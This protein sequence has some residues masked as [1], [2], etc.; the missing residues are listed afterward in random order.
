MRTWKHTYLKKGKKGLKK[1]T[2]KDKNKAKLSYTC[3]PVT[4][5]LEE[6][7]QLMERQPSRSARRRRP[8]ALPAEDSTEKSLEDGSETVLTEGHR[9]MQTCV[10]CF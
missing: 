4:N 2:A 3:V 5:V 9:Y 1:K 6:I 10:L 7:M 8:L